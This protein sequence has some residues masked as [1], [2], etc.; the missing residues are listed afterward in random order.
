MHKANKN[1][2]SFLFIF[3]FSVG[4][5]AAI[6]D[7]VSPEVSV[8]PGQDVADPVVIPGRDEPEVSVSL[9]QDVLALEAI[10]GPDMP[11]VAAIHDQDAAAP[12]LAAKLLEEG[13]S[14]ARSPQ[15]VW[16]NHDRVV[17]EAEVTLDQDVAVDQATLDPAAPELQAT[18]DL[19]A[20]VDH[21]ARWDELGDQGQREHRARRCNTKVQRELMPFYLC[22]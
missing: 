11:E 15:E 13:R 16:A 18:L 19:G 1:V 5:W 21:R 9:D 10:P 4:V 6:P 14:E 12:R 22:F 3:I 2:R 7:P 20:G 17:L 8:G